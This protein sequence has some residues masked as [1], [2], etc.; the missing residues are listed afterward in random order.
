M[1][2]CDIWVG[3]SCDSEPLVT[4]ALCATPFS[5]VLTYGQPGPTSS[6]NYTQGCEGEYSICVSN[7]G[8]TPL[9]SLNIA[10]IFPALSQI[11]VQQVCVS[12]SGGP[13]MNYNINFNMS[14]GGPTSGT[15]NV[16]SNQCFNFAGPF[17]TDMTFAT[18]S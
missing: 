18:T 8:N 9:T 7:S 14:S 11:E 5:K 12:S 4:A 2:P 13:T 6:I 15:G 16:G 10:D 3:S 17:P 1:R